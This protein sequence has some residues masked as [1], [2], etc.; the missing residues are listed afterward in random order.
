MKDNIYHIKL[1]NGDDILGAVVSED[2]KFA[3]ISDPMKISESGE[4]GFTSMIL[5]KYMPFSQEPIINIPISYIMVIKKIDPDFAIYYHR[6]LEYH[7]KYITRLT[8][9]NIVEAN[10]T[11]ERLLSDENDQFVKT[12]KSRNVDLSQ[13][14]R[15][16]KLH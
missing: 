6:T 3:Y 2:E 9:D 7:Q 8:H 1:I 13:L 14:N 12:A 4:N 5:N 16:K 11:M 15:Q 10:I